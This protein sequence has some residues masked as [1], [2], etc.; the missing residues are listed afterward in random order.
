MHITFCCTAT[1]AG[2][3]LNDL[4]AA[5]PGSTISLWQPGAPAADYAIV[6][7]PPQAFFD[8]QPRLKVAFNIGAGVDALLRLNIAPTTQLVRLDDA[9]MGAQMAEYV[10]HALIRH[11]RSFDG[12]DLDQ[13]R[14]IWRQREV[15][16]RAEM[17][18]GIMGLGVLGTRVAKAVAQFDFPVNGWSRTEKA[19]PGVRCFHGA[20]GFHDF[21][22]ASKVLVSVLPATPETRDL[23][24]RDTLS[25][26]QPGGYLINVAR[27]A[28]VVEEDLLAL[29][30]AGH[31]AGAAL[32][33]FRTEPLPAGHPFWAHPKIRIT[34]HTAALTIRADSIAQIAT[35]IA[36][37]Q[38][39]KPVVGLVNRQRGY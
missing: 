16:P 6:W 37:M 33:V 26:L 29:I 30:D 9:G 32:D 19:V 27:G 24:N 3:W 17:P 10:C 15:L 7:Q 13:T 39:G 21:L 38:S 5:L 14:G 4:R 18:V 23:I 35:K 20:A 22:A 25:R 36:A 2:P 8:E 11:Y 34:P 12:Y 31:M 28:Q 1:E